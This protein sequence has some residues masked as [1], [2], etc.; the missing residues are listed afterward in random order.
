METGGWNTTGNREGYATGLIAFTLEEVGITPEN[1]RLKSGLS[2]LA[3][4]D[5][6]SESHAE[7]IFLGFFLRNLFLMHVWG[8]SSSA[9]TS[10]RLLKGR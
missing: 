1:A 7:N 5:S 9:M 2:W 8:F 6:T 10:C 4:Q 3:T